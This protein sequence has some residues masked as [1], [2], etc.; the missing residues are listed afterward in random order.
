VVPTLVVHARDDPTPAFALAEETARRIPGAEF[1]SVP[2]GG[3]LLLGHHDEVR[4]AISEFLLAHASA[5]A[6]EP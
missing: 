1:L 2:D 4:R 3:H 6:D 5:E